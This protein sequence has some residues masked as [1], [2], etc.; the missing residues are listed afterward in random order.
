VGAAPG[1]DLE[2]RRDE[3]EDSGKEYADKTYDSADQHLQRVIQAV[4]QPIEAMVDSSF[5]TVEASVYLVEPPVDLVEPPV[6]VIEPPV[7]IRGEFVESII[8]PAPW[9]RVNG[10][11]HRHAAKLG[12]EIATVVRRKPQLRASFGTGLKS[13]IASG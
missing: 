1:L 11:H 6:D 2:L 5:Q 9:F 12:R 13:R 7:D 4:V 3:G 8:V 10:C